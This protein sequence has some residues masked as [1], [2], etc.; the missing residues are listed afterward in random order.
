MSTPI[1]LADLTTA[2]LDGAGV[3]DVLMRANKAHLEAEFN[4][5]RIKGPEYATVYL[6]SLEAVMQAALQFLLAK[7]KSAAEIALIEA[8]T[9]L[10]VQ[11]KENLI[12]EKALT[13]EKTANAIL[14]GTVLVAQ[15][16][17]LRAEYDLTLKTVDKAVQEIALLLQKV[18]T[19]R[20]QTVGA[21]VDQDSVIGKQKTLYQAQTDGF[22]R[23]AEQK[24]AKTLID[25][26]NVR[27]TT[28][29]ATVADS[30][31]L[32]NDATIGRAVTKL[33]TGVGA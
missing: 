2:T 27:R 30:T 9:A 11:Q 20:A 10:A 26:W 4:K 32:L 21:G 12:A 31:N 19:E 17:K 1:V 5:N 16:C 13:E 3:F 22:A 24:A 14:E 29:E 6:G 15:E 18:A 8:Q 28:D 33:L 7:Q 23:D 25:T